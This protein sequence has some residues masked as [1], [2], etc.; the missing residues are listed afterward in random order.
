MLL[1]LLKL[2]KLSWSSN[3][4]WGEPTC[5]DSLSEEVWP[6]LDS[7]LACREREESLPSRRLWGE[8]E[9]RRREMEVRREKEGAES[10]FVEQSRAISRGFSVGS[11]SRS[12]II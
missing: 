7:E 5:G 4:M 1:V 12:P 8:V 9:L 10:P 6:K 3:I 2:Y 11:S